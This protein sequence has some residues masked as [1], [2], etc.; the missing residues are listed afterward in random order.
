M[1][2]HE[3]HVHSIYMLLFDPIRY[4]YLCSQKPLLLLRRNGDSALDWETVD[5]GVEVVED[6]VLR[7]VSN[8]IMREDRFEVGSGLDL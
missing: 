7:A 2:L 6:D 3:T 8:K 5:G 1:P 4:S